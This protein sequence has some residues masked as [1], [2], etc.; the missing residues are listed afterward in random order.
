MKQACSLSKVN[1]TDN[2]ILEAVLIDD[3]PD[4]LGEKGMCY[5]CPETCKLILKSN[6]VLEK[7]QDVKFQAIGGH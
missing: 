6:Y 2:K 4:H 1:L 3:V 5:V 7:T